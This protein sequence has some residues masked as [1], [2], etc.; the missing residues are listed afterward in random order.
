[1]CKPEFSSA[2]KTPFVIKNTKNNHSWASGWWEYTKNLVL[3]R[4]LRYFSKGSTTQ[5][6]ITISRKNLSL[7]KTQKAASSASVWW[8][9]PNLVLKRMLEFFLNVPPL[10]KKLE[11]QN[12]K[13]RL[14]NL[15]KRKISNQKSSQWLKTC[16]LNF[17]N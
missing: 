15:Y 4:M 3:K 13:K 11:F 16:K 5:E 6:Y 7:L 1:M 8:G 10:K 17:T 2:A 14:W 12:Q 9:T